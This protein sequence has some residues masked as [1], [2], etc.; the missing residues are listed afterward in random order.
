MLFLTQLP[1]SSSS[2]ALASW[3]KL[4]F[5]ACLPFPTDF[6]ASIEGKYIGTYVEIQE[7]LGQK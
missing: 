4:S 6:A 2:V 7:R 1:A 5:L 3:E